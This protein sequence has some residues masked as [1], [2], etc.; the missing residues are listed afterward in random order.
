MVLKVLVNVE[1]DVTRIHFK[2]VAGS[3][4]FRT[5]HREGKRDIVC[6]CH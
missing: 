2:P 3:V 5:G 4:D 1:K 6:P